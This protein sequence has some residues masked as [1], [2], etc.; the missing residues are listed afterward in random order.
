[1]ASGLSHIYGSLEH[2]DLRSN[3]IFE[4]KAASGD[5]CQYAMGEAAILKAIEN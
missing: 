4:E 5:E 3:F 1:V 2:Q